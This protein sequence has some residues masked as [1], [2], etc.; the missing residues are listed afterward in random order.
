LIAAAYRGLAAAA[1]F[2]SVG[3]PRNFR[4]APGVHETVFQATRGSSPFD[5]IALHRYARDSR[6][7]AHPSIVMLYLPGTNMNGEA[8]I[9]D[10][11]Y[12][13]EIYFAQQSVDLWA[14]DYRTHFIPQQTPPDRLIELR[15]W[16]D[17]LFESDIDMAA[18]YVMQRTAR[19]RIFVAGFSR[20]ATFAYLYAAQH[21]KHVQGLVIF[22]GMLADG[23]EGAPPPGDYT[24]D[25]GGRHLTW[26]KR[27]TLL[28]MVIENP[29][30]R[31]PIPKYKTAGDNLANVVYYSAGF[32]GK[33]GLANPFGGFS[34]L[35][36]LARTLIGYDRYW[37]IVQDYKDPEASKHAEALAKS[38]IPVIAFSSTNIA[39]DWPQRVA[40]SAASTGSK[41]VT[42]KRLTGWG[43][44]D[45]ICGSHAEQQ[46]FAPAVEWVKRH[47]R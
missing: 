17:E 15:D 4:S 41:D 31:A 32:G 34:D 28:R 24:T 1:D 11:R 30:G 27:Q 6:S 43:H 29:V 33:G 13:L 2:D 14:L 19:N 40:K 25:V 45:L 47:Q 10:P 39:P 21:P 7:S 3:A 23:R 8:A 5:H 12:A 35:N 37:P 18:Q 42:V 20:G 22:D 16:T 36:A 44:L 9:D 26:D 38:K 46:V